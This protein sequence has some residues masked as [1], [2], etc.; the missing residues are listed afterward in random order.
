MVV[1]FFQEL[2]AARRC[3]LLE[4]LE[5][6]RVPT[7]ALLNENPGNAIRNLKLLLFSLELFNLISNNLV[8]GEVALSG[9]PVENVLVQRIIE[10][11]VEEVLSG[12]GGV[13]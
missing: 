11:E 5:K 6:I 4:G 12:N 13:S 7:L 10:I 3:Q 8:R 2:N 1:R 9:C